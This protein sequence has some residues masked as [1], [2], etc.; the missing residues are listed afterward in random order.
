MILEK[1]YK[2]MLLLNGILNIRLVFRRFVE[3]GLHGPEKRRL[4][5]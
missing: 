4:D 1:R 5:A 2:V 3:S